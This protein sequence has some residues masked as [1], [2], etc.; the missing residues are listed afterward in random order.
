MRTEAQR[1]ARHGEARQGREKAVE[2]V[3]QWKGIMDRTMSQSHE[4]GLREKEKRPKNNART[5]TDFED[6]EQTPSFLFL[7][8]RTGTVATTGLKRRVLDFAPLLAMLPPLTYSRSG[9]PI[10]LPPFSPFD[11]TNPEADLPVGL[12]FCNRRHQSHPCLTRRQIVGR[13]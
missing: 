8:V 11:Q 13:Y 7:R 10:T 6:I 1:K 3:S 12:P 9:T 4:G 2:D 5:D